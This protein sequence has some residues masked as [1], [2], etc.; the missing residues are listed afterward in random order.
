[1]PRATLAYLMY[2]IAPNALWAQ[3]PGS[4]LRSYSVPLNDFDLLSIGIVLLFV[5]VI[6]LIRKIRNARNASTN[7]IND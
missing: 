2:L 7:K 6:L 1:M 5:M 3:E 4:Q